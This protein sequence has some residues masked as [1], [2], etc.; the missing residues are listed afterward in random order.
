[1]L[2]ELGVRISDEYFESN[3]LGHSFEHVTAKILADFDVALASS[4]SQDYQTKLMQVFAV[5]LEPTVGLERMLSE[6]KV[7]YCVATSS[8]PQRVS[9]ALEITRIGHYFGDQ[10][11]TSSEVKNGKPAPDLFLYAAEKM[12]V[13]PQCCLVIEDSPAGI[14]GAKAAQ[15]QVIRYAGAGHMQQWRQPGESSVDDLTTI[16]NWQAL[17]ALAPTL[18]TIHNMRDKRG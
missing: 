10:V 3:F 9:R 5:E 12:G 14:Q 16:K 2:L 1:M 4:F 7:P 18:N 8:S 17:Y 15:M 11:F 6:L 13:H